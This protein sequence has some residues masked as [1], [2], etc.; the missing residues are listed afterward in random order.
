MEKNNIEQCE[1]V[2]RFLLPRSIYK[3][4]KIGNS[5]LF[6]HQQIIITQANSCFGAGVF[7]ADFI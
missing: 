7:G 6:E 2:R 5:I 1:N 3:F 4:V